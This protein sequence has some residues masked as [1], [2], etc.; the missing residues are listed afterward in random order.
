MDVNEDFSDKR[1]VTFKP[2]QREFTHF[3][4]RSNDKELN[5]KITLLDSFAISVMITPRL[6]TQPMELR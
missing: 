1:N 4:E 5:T 2:E 6:I 3:T